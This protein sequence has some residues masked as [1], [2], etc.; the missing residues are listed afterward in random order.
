[1]FQKQDIYWIGLAGTLIVGGYSLIWSSEPE[2]RSFRLRD[3]TTAQK[4]ESPEPER[5][6]IESPTS[7]QVL[8]L[9][10]T[11]HKNTIQDE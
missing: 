11:N 8:E 3:E 5:E 1:M 2:I 9:A 4:E 6:A 10:K 7:Q